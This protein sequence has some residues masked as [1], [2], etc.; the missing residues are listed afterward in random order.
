M[1]SPMPTPVSRSGS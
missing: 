1:K